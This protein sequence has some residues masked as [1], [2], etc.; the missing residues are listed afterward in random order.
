MNM[1]RTS[2]KQKSRRELRREA[3]TEEIVDTAAG[4]VRE[5]G[6]DG[7]TMPGLAR[8]LDAAVGAIYRYFA[9][10]DALVAA[11]QIRAIGVF[12]GRLAAA[13]AGLDDP[14]DR[15]RAGWNCWR[16]FAEADPE[17]HGLIDQGL[18]D[19]R[20]LLEDADAAAVQQALDPLLGRVAD[21]I[22]AAQASGRFSDGDATLRAHALWAALHGVDHFRKRDPRLPAELHSDRVAEAL[23]EGLIAGWSARSE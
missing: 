12:A 17:I 5:E 9:G 21:A 18:S 3:R 13:V 10:K 23:L 16:A 6:I 15:I 7:L 11:L 22:A 20:Q 2:R 4:I 8:E 19:P 1:V 14:V